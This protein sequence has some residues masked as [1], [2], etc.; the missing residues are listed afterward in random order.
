MP[1]LQNTTYSTPLRSVAASA[2]I[3]IAGHVYIPVQIHAF[4][5]G[6]AVLIAFLVLSYVALVTVPKLAFSARRSAQ[7]PLHVLSLFSFSSLMADLIRCQ[8]S[9]DSA[10][11]DSKAKRKSRR[12]TVLICALE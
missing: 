8:P 9:R 10:V 12:R 7:R 11:D 6:A 5:R 1:S 2:G 4:R 3:K